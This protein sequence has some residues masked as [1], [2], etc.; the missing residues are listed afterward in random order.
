MCDR[1]RETELSSFLSN[2]ADISSVPCELCEVYADAS[3]FI[4][5]MHLTRAGKAAAQSR[6]GWGGGVVQGDEA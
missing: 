6:V 2:Y 5:L 1:E 4:I 3:S